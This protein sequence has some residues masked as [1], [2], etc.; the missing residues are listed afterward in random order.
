MKHF[1]DI[2]TTPQNDLRDIIGHIQFASVPDRG[3]PDHGELNYDTIFAALADWNKPL[4]AE[5]KPTED[6]DA[7]LG[8]MRAFR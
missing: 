6:T 1:L 8:W 4:G 3:T 2:H 5:Y 7:T